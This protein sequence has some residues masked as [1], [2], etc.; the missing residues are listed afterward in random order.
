MV[1]LSQF[2]QCLVFFEV[3]KEVTNAGVKMSIILIYYCTYTEHRQTMIYIYHSHTK[4]KN[5]K[6]PLKIVIANLYIIYLFTLAF[7][8]PPILV[9]GARKQPLLFRFLCTFFRLLRTK[10]STE[11]TTTV[12]KTAARM[13]THKC[14]PSL[15]GTSLYSAVGL[16][17]G[18]T[19]VEDAITGVDGVKVTFIS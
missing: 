13:M 11:T 6:R 8:Y 4:V 12:A 3:K 18:G 7:T 5:R 10:S 17:G 2:L 15:P 14:L 16:V 19:T 9:F 1:N